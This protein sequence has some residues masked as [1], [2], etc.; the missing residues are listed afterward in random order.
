MAIISRTIYTQGQVKIQSGT[1]DNAWA[2]VS[3]VQSASVSYSSP[4]QTVNSFGTRGII[5][6]VQLEPETASTTF[7]FILPSGT[8]LGS[9]DKFPSLL[10]L[11]IQVAAKTVGF[12]IV[13]VIPM[14]GPTGVLSYLDYVYAGGKL[15][16]TDSVSPYTANTPDLIKVP[17]TTASPVTGLTVGS[18]YL[19]GA[20]GLS[21]T[22]D[23]A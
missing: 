2:L 16:G 17:T 20:S 7:S 22:K 1:N 12:D 14:S 4:N 15:S 23:L 9:G 11:A 6:N 13:P 5:D 21:S 19:L 18:T 10:P 3:G 8:G